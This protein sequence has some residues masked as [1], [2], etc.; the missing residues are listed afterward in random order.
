MGVV[1]TFDVLKSLEIFLSVTDTGSMTVASRRLGITQSAIS[2]QIKL[3]E[4]DIGT[5]LFDRQSRPLRL[6]TAGITLHQRATR[7]VLDAKET[8]TCTRQASEVLIAH[9]RLALLSTIATPLVPAIMAASN[10]KEVAVQTISIM[11]GISRNHTQDLLN[12]EIDV[13]I[14]SDALY[15]HEAIER[16]ELVQESFI[17]LLPK[18]ANVRGSDL[19][20]IAAR[21]PFL[22]YT[23]RTQSGQLIERHFRRLRLDISPNF[24]FEAPDDLIAGVAAGYGWSVITPTQLAY[25][26]TDLSTVEVARFPSPGLSRTITLIARRGE[27]PNVAAQ[28]AMICRRVLRDKVQ[29]RVSAFLHDMPDAYCLAEEMPDSLPVP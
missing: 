13:A 6:T 29:P 23:S 20:T 22:R 10:S 12:R 27:F 17:L 16:H 28:L 15:E 24:L 14:T 26:L 19:R 5:Q 7:L 25:S 2:Q 21:L 11:R 18:G 9:L 3:L 4:A 8:W 1:P